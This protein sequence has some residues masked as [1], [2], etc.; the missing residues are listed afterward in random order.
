MSSSSP[1]QKAALK[2]SLAKH[3][4]ELDEARQALEAATE[5]ATRDQLTL[6]IEILE[7]LVK[8]ELLSLSA[9]GV[10]IESVPVRMRN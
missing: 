7:Q 1:N 2:A 3:K 6:E 10:D 9:L 8:D 5:P 4:R